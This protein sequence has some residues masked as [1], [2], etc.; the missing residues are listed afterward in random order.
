MTFVVLD[1]VTKRFG[2]VLAVDNVSLSI[3]KGEFVV[4]LGPSGCG[5]TTT[6]RM[7]AGLE[8]PTS[9]RIYIDGRDVTYLEPG[10]RDVAMVFQDYAIYPHMTVFENIAFP[11]E[12]QRRK[13]RLT[14]RDIE[15]KVLQVA[16]MLQIDHLLDRKASQLSGG[17]QQRVALAR[18]LVREPK[19]W[20]MDEPLS[21]LDALI[22]L[23]VR[24]ELKRLQKDLGI[25]TIYVTH[26]Q[27]EALTLADR[28]AVM[29]AGRVVQFGTPKEIYDAPTHVFVGTFVGNPPMNILKCKPAG[30]VLECPGFTIKNP[31]VKQTVFFGIRPEYIEWSDKEQPG[32][33]K[34]LVYVVEPIGSEYLINVK[35]ADVL[36]KI[37]TLSEVSLKPGDSIYFKFDMK[38]AVL[39]DEETG[40]VV[41]RGI[42]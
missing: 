1:R 11:L 35:I 15:E 3:E 29:N 36:L 39:F 26:D 10:E 4:F 32:Y 40:N 22:R 18:A 24:A 28:I 34:G 5:K 8:I 16:K 31:G 41:I 14:K 25:T 37:K 6:L 2:K 9:G 13:L 30:D 12:I 27:V 17:Q 33:I 20:L 38:K 7:I 19:V 42:E 23:Q 21:N